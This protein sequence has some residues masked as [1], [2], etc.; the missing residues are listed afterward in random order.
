MQH[1]IGASV[2]VVVLLVDVVV[3]LLVDVVVELV[4]DVVVVVVAV[5]LVVLVELEVV[6]VELVVVVAPTGQ[7]GRPSSPV[8]VQRPSLHWVVMFFAQLVPL[9]LGPHAA[10]ISSLQAVFLSHLPLLSAIAEGET[11]TPAAS[12]TAA[13][14]TT[15]FVIV[16]VIVEPP[17]AVPIARH[18]FGALPLRQRL[19]VFYASVNGFFDS[20][21][22]YKSAGASVMP[23]ISSR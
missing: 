5:V 11:K 15:T 20:Y 13:N 9:E 3:V 23:R 6:V 19:G 21:A 10:R 1:W 14:V 22:K 18:R 8:Q 7:T 17:V 2:V 12:V 16:L 4:V